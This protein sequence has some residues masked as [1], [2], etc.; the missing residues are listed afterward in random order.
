MNNPDHIY[1]SLEKP[2]FGVKILKFFAADLAVNTVHKS[3][4]GLDSKSHFLVGPL[5]FLF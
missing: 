5:N 3:L 4:I 2:F 1:E